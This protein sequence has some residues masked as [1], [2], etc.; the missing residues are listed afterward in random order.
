MKPSRDTVEL[1]SARLGLAWLGLAWPMDWLGSVRV[2]SPA[3]L[4]SPLVDSALF[5]HKFGLAWPYYFSH[6]SLHVYAQL[7][8]AKLIRVG[9]LGF[10]L[11]QSL[12]N[13]PAR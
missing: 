7:V 1:G 8:S 4:R 9:S 2:S 6:L 12:S 3:L 5:G 10:V 11:A 13:R